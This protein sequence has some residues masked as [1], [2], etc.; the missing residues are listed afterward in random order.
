MKFEYYEISVV[1]VSLSNNCT[2]IIVYVYRP[3]DKLKIPEFSIKLNESLSTSQ[4]DRVFLVG[5]IN[6][7]M[8]DPIAMKNDFIKNCHSN[9]LIPLI[10]KPTRHA[11]NNLSILDHLLT[12]QLYDTFNGLFLL[13]ITDHY[14]IFTNAPINC[15]QKQIRVKFRDHTGQNL[16][17]LK[18]EVEHYLNNHVQINQDVNANTNNF[19]NSLFIIYSQCCP[20][21]E[22]AFTRL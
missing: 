15:P 19:C 17:K 11:N 8:L 1:K 4:S 20:I 7:N 16:A 2:V 10:N 9:S 5:N 14:P 18:I 3:P 22:K 13:D 12:N 6:I 21:K